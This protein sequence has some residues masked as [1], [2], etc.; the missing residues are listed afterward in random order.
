[1]VEVL[2]DEEGYRL[3]R[4]GILEVQ[5]MD[6]HGTYRHAV[7]KL[8]AAQALYP[9]TYPVQLEQNPHWLADRIEGPNITNVVKRTF[10]QMLFK[11]QLGSKEPCAGCVLAIPQAVWDSW[12]RHLG[13]PALVPQPDGTHLLSVPG[14]E[15]PAGINTAILVFDMDVSASVRS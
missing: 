15:V 14:G 6:Y 9:D 2:A 10:Y 4:Y 1:M 5:T 11:F 7:E 12:Q 8:K 13:R 3:G